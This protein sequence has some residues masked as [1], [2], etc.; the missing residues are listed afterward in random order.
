MNDLSI[1][2]LKLVCKLLKEERAACL[3]LGWMS[4]MQLCVRALDELEPELNRREK[5]LETSGI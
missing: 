2:T 1:R 3:E 4:D 5:A